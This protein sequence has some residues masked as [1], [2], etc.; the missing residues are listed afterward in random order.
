MKR[1][2]RIAAWMLVWAMFLTIGSNPSFAAMAEE[3][4]V[5]Y[6]VVEE[7]VI[8]GAGTQTIMI[9][10]GD[11]SR[12]IETALL[13]Y[14]NTGT[15]ERFET[16]AKEILGDFVMFQM[17]FKDVSQ[18][19]AYRL[20]S[21]SYTAGG[22]EYS[23]SF[24][25]MGIEASFGV[26]EI[27][28]NE[29][30]DVLLTDEELEALAAETEVNIVSLDGE[31][32][33][34]QGETLE[35]AMESAGCE[36]YEEGMS[37]LRK[38]AKDGEVDASGMSSLIVV[39]D[40]GHGGSDPGTQANGIV[41]KTVNLKIAQYCKAELEEYAGLTVYMT[42]TDDT[43]LS[44]AQR[45]Q[46]AI[47]KKANVFVSLHNNANTSAVPN[48]ANVYYPN[49]NYNANCGATGQAL[50]S[51]ILSKLTALGLASGGIHI[52]N[53]ENGTK[54][55]DGSLAD[56]YG[57]IKRCKENGIPALIV[58]HAFVTNASDAQK[59]L[60]TDEQLKKLGVADATGIAEYYG[61]KKGLG[62][63][64]V[65]SKSSTTMELK[66]TQVVGV[67]GYCI[68]RSESSG[69]GFE[70]IAR[71]K[72]STVTVWEDKELTPGTTYYYKIRTYT[73]KDT[74]VKYG[75]YSTV[76]SAS[77]MS[78]PG[79]SSIKSKNSKELEISWATINNAAN[80][81]IYRST[82]KNGTYKKI[83]TVAGVNRVN[84]VDRSVK[85]GKKYYYKIRSIGQV[86][87]TTIYSDYSDPM[88][89]RTAKKP[90]NVS[91]KSEATDTLR[92]SWTPD[93]N[94]SGYIIKR[95]DSANGSYKKVGTA[96]G[97]DLKYFD[98]K[99]VKPYQTYY[100]KVQAYNYNKDTKGYSDYSG[101]AYGKTIKKTSI[102]KI[103]STSSS[104]Q[105]ITWKKASGVNGY[106]IYQS[107]SKDGK[108]KKIK[109]IS[110]ANTTSYK[111]TGLTPGVKYYYKVRTRKKEKG[112]TEYG[113]YSK[114]R[115][116]WAGKKA[117][118][119]SV[120]GSTGSSLTVF[121]NPVKGAEKYDIYRASSEKGT[122]KKIASVSKSDVSYTDKKLKMKA[123]YYYK[124]EAFV[125]G[126]KA[127]GTSGMSKAASGSPLSSTIITSAISNAQGQ[128]ELTW[129]PVK[130]IS[131]Y[132]IYRSVTPD[133]GYA[134]I[135]TVSD[136]N[137][138]KYTDASVAAGA[139]YY[140]KI[141]IFGVYNNQTIYG[142]ASAAV[143]VSLPLPAAVALAK[144]LFE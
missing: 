136:P 105:T 35:E 139:K 92:V 29:P 80:Y 135:A 113:S 12:E 69:S 33:P 14:R 5:N 109:T 119:T 50:A 70:E 97:G 74:G 65:Q 59:Y 81:E 127:T 128:I 23:A 42:R 114:P 46:V 82:K 122:Y 28:E 130:D 133:S 103:V 53:S 32:K 49:S 47:N 16:E 108:Y 19:G 104:K 94:A 88:P 2:K 100:Y 11:G 107:E 38:G 26:N 22:Q 144:P 24:E 45:A 62:F 75:K 41:E 99:T 6:L 96:S 61:L 52:R 117:K 58:E 138:S 101:S 121:W 37:A 72:P 25:E 18:N 44:L 90:A 93:T 112:K 123:V 4:L 95:A 124:V 68:Y 106:V 43:Y 57:V 1:I 54:Y 40:P 125:K 9:G 48:G 131:G 55:P 3:Q 126:Y 7:P 78:R 77:T 116:S 51:S 98:D 83:A 79:I 34:A 8:T 13:S 102:T 15:D 129:N 87:N 60:S 20:D 86:D 71:I 67:T 137:M 76:V 56:Y 143:A 85:E 89:A 141:A 17:E 134:L 63:N 91:V 36:T 66:W 111:V 73:E 64:S 10:I 27:V 31:G 84:Y 30:D 132:Q 120:Q 39:L 140:Y 21:I 142:D 115:Y 118:V 110:S